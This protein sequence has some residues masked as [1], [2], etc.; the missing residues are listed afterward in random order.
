RELIDTLPTGR[1]YQTV[2][3]G[4]PAVSAQ[5]AVRFDVGGSSVMQQ[6]S[7]A[8]YGG[9]PG[10]F[11]LMV[12]N[13]SVSTPIG[14]GDRPGLYLNDG[15]FEESVYIVN[16]GTAEVQT[17]GIKTN[18]IPK[19]GGNRYKAEF[20]TTFSNTSMQ[21]SNIDANLTARGFVGSNT[22]Y[23]AYDINPTF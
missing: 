19:Q 7:G 18:L 5:G 2:M 6:G 23:R 9:R 8:A 21:G 1:N 16:A 17:P 10:D 12:D 15:G 3:Q 4:L 14:N 20:L 11:A 13:M 22:L